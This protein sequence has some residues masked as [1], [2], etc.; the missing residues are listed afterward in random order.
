MKKL[1]ISILLGA[2]LFSC[3]SN[4]ENTSKSEE[5]LVFYAGLQEDHA[6]LI[7][8]KFT[9][10]TGIPTEFVRMSS[11]ET[12][13]RLK[14]EKNNMV[15]SVWYGG[16]VDGIIAADAEGLVEA[17]NSPT[18][19]EIL[20]QFKS[21][22]GRWTGIYVGY[23]GFV[24]NKKILKEKGLEMPKSWQDLLDP[25]FKGEIVVAH[26][27]SSGTAYTMLATLVQLMG[28]EQA[29]SYFKQL[30]GQIR[31]YTKSG[32]APGRMVGSGEVALGITFLHDAIKY[33]K[34]GYSDIIISSP[35][36]GTGYEIGAV[37]L[38]KNAPNSTAAK[39]FIDWVLTKEVQELG[40]TVGSFQFLTNKNAVAPEE[41]EPIKNT[42][43]INY[44][45]EWAGKNRK[46]LVEKYT[47][48]TSS[49]IPQK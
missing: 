25:K 30:D 4:S 45:F 40:K 20:D 19:E 13:A 34:E 23:L 31:Q 44:D 7:A 11:G 41:A 17:Y 36:E 15:A 48:E 5:K 2:F 37:A 35:N 6:A 24:G 39:K 26:P 10:E 1:L 29:M 8:E 38:L 47:K 22:D 46:N 16:P 3:G 33:Q 14:A 27:G 42:K 21:G 12:L 43:L 9:D 18:A 32:T 49:T 28:E